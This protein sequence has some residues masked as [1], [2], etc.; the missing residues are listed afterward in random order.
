MGRGDMCVLW[1]YDEYLR[2]VQST[3]PQRNGNGNARVDISSRLRDTLF[4]S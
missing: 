3:I 4:W 2:R 1:S